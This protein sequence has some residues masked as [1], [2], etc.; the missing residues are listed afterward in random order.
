[1][2]WDETGNQSHGRCKATELFAAL[3]FTLPFLFYLLN[4]ASF[5]RLCEGHYTGM[6]D[7]PMRDISLAAYK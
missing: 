6:A 7:T 1:M 4:I 3:F 5:G 2:E